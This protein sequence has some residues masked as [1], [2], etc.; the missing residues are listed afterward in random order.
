LSLLFYRGELRAVE[1]PRAGIFV[2]AKAGEM[3]YRLKNA[4]E[5]ARR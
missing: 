1:A 5:W 3:L 4:P 2:V